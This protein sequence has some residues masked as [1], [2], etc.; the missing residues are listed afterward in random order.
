M[1]V[2]IAN[3]AALTAV[4]FRR[5]LQVRAVDR[6]ARVGVGLGFVAMLFAGFAWPL[7][8][9]GAAEMVVGIATLWLN[10]KPPDERAG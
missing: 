9:I 2:P 5:G 4:V 1:A 3:L 7:A 8:L 10:A 6:I